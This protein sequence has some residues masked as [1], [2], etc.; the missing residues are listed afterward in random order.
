MVSHLNLS[1]SWLQLGK[2]LAR[3][4]LGASPSLA[5]GPP[6][7][8]SPCRECRY[9]KHFPPHEQLKEPPVERSVAL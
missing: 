8:H 5:R 6:G 9:V 4:R 7:L 3:E 2:I 1:L